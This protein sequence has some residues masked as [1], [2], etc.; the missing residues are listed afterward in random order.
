MSTGNDSPGV[1]QLRWN[2]WNPAFAG[3]DGKCRTPE[4]GASVACGAGASVARHGAPPVCFGPQFARLPTT[5]Q[6]PEG[7]IR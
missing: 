5:F 4:T 2:L 1:R 3:N 7:D 6:T